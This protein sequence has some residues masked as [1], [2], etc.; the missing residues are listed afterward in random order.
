[1]EEKFEE[2]LT[3]MNLTDEAKR[4]PLRRKPIKEKRTMLAMQWRGAAIQVLISYSLALG[5]IF[6]TVV[7]E[8][9]F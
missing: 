4:A 6:R 1:M 7:S 5:Y 8:L 2:M 3:D 9:L